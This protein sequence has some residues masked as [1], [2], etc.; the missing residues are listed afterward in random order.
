MQL[1]KK[2]ILQVLKTIKKEVKLSVHINDK[3]IFLEYPR[4]PLKKIL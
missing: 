2:K 1:E 3:T 4:E